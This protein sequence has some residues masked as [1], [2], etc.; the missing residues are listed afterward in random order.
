MTK[1]WVAAHRVGHVF[2]DTSLKHRHSGLWRDYRQSSWS[3]AANCCPLS[4]T[5]AK[6]WVF[7]YLDSE[8]N[9][10][11]KLGMRELASPFWYTKLVFK[12]VVKVKKQ[13][14]SAIAANYASCREPALRL[15]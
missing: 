7:V 5:H 2:S 15:L 10:C 9:G 13:H 8:M 4:E 11:A 1:M 14:V 6:V 3:D 12:L